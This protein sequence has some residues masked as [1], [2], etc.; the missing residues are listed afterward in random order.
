[1]DP[2]GTTVAGIIVTEIATGLGEDVDVVLMII[3]TSKG[4][5]GRMVGKKEDLPM[6]G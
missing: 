6:K 4:N 5:R 1:M 2:S 3:T